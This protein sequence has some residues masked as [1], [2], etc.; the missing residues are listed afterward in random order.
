MAIWTIVNSS[1]LFGGLEHSANAA[2]APP[3]PVYDLAM[4]AIAIAVWAVTIAVIA[5]W[6]HLREESAARAHIRSIRIARRDGGG[7]VSSSPRSTE[8]K[9]KRRHPWVKPLERSG[10]GR[11]FLMRRRAPF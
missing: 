5:A 10:E 2:A 9:P 1:F 7:A 11:G 4:A 3:I 8:D 6:L